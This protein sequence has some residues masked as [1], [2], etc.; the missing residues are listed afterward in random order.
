[1]S[2]GGCGGS[3]N[4]STLLNF[5]YYNSG[6]N[7][8]RNEIIQFGGFLYISLQGDNQNHAPN[9]NPV[10]WEQTSVSELLTAL[11]NAFP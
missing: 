3:D 8:D 6:V 10:W 2:C 11:F 1:M 4:T 9:I 5:R 7:Y